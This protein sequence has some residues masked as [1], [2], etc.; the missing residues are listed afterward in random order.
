MWIKVSYGRGKSKDEIKAKMLQAKWKEFK[1]TWP[2]EMKEYLEDSLTMLISLC[3]GLGIFVG[4]LIG[5]AVLQMAGL[6]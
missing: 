5:V 2:E 4:S 3:F 6:I 1:V